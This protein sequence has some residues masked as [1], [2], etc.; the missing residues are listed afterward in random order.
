MCQL[1]PADGSGAQAALKDWQGDDR[2]ACLEN[3]PGLREI[4]VEDAV[5]HDGAPQPRIAAMTDRL[6]NRVAGA[7]KSSLE[8]LLDLT[9]RLRMRAAKPAH[10]FGVAA[11]R[12]PIERML[13]GIH[14]GMVSCIQHYQTSPKKATSDQGARK[15]AW[16]RPCSASPATLTSSSR[17]T[18]GGSARGMKPPRGPVLERL[19]RTTAQSNGGVLALGG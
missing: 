15:V 18:L 5:R 14:R 3:H 1:S 10:H 6:P 13:N 12:P 16:S 17:R 4:V 8:P 19:I 2:A 9:P 11:V 7:S